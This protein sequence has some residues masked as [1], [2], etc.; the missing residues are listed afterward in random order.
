[1]KTCSVE[2]C[3]V[4]FFGRGYCRRHYKQ[5]MRNGKITVGA[6]NKTTKNKVIDMGDHFAMEL[7][8]QAGEVI[9]ETLISKDSYN[10]IKDFKWSYSQG[11]V[12]SRLKGTKRIVKLHRIITGAPDGKEVDHINGL[13]LDNRIENLRICT[14][15]ENKFNTGVRKNNSTGIRGVS[16]DPLRTSYKK[17]HASIGVNRKIIHLGY[18]LTKQEAISVRFNAEIKY[19]GG[20]SPNLSRGPQ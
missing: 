16:Y 2:G 3:D 8:S 19:Y 12:A 1:M 6:Y 11:Y 17:W 13:P 15:K 14:T 5:F 9:C 7:Y 4:K 10:K 20:F 18:Y